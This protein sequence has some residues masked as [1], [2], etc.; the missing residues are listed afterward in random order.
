VLFAS[1]ERIRR[2]LGWAPRYEDIDVIVETAWRW[3]TA[4]PQG[5]GDRGARI[6]GQTTL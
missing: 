5:Y 6:E 2:V 3:R 4:H 1:S